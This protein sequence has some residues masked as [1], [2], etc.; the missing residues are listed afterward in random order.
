[1]AD[2]VDV[3]NRRARIVVDGDASR[4]AKLHAGGFKPQPSDVGPPTGGKHDAIDDHVVVARQFDAKPVFDL[5]DALDDF[6][7][8]DPDAAVLHLG[9]QMRAQ[10]VV[11]AAQNVV[12]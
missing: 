5:F 4:H 1:V 3:G 6:L 7:G 12:A 11:E 10:V 2:G 8:D 9:S